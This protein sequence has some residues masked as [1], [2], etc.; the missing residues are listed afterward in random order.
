MIALLAIAALV[1][2]LI[3]WA[4]VLQRRRGARGAVR[5]GGL[6]VGA[7]TLMLGCVVALAPD[8][9]ASNKVRVPVMIGNSFTVPAGEACPFTLHVEIVGGNQV[10]TFFDDGRF[11]ATGRRIQRVT[12]VDSGTSITLDLEGSVDDVPTADGGSITRAGGMTVIEFFPGD[13]GPGDTETA[14]VYLFTGDIMATSDPSGAFTTFTSAGK[15][16][17][18]CA[19]LT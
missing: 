16:Q 10:L 18:V 4:P 2:L 8:A 7:V 1:V 13:A 14:R 6:L 19:M 9:S 12:N 11:H 17:D 15:S 3:G 5:R